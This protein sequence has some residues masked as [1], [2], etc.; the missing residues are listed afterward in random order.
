MSLLALS[1]TNSVSGGYE[2]GNSLKLEDD[3][4]EGMAKNFTGDGDRRT[5]TY[6]TWVKRTEITGSDSFHLFGASYSNIQ[7]MTNDLLRVELYDG[8]N[9]RYA[10]L[11]RVFRD[12]SAWYH[13]VV[14][15]DSTQST[16][17]DRVKIYI[18]GVQDTSFNNSTYT[19][20]SQNDQFDFGS[21]SA[22]Y[23]F[24][25][26][27]AGGS[28]DRRFCGYVAET[29]YVN[30]T[31]LDETS[32]GEFDSDTGIWIPKEYTGS[33]GSKGFYFK[34]D[35]SSNL[36]KDSASSGIGDFTL[37]NITAADQAVDTPTNNFCTLSPLN[38]E[39]NGGGDVEYTEGA[40]KAK[41]LAAD[42]PASGSMAITKGK[43]YFEC[44]A[45]SNSE[46]MAGWGV[47]NS[48]GTSTD[49][50]GN[51][52]YSFAVHPV[53]RVYY[54]GN[55]YIDFSPSVSFDTNDIISVAIDAD[56]GFCYWAKNGTY[57]NSATPTSGATGTGGFN[58]LS[59]S[60]GANMKIVDGDFL[61]PAFRVNY[62]TNSGILL[63]FGGYTTITISSAASDAN[64]YGV[65]EYAPPSGYYAL[66][67]K[68]LAEFG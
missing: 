10:D 23:Q 13:I 7:F 2:I 43:W 67:T 42:E 45:L 54:Y 20:M 66:C 27:F 68:N 18:N 34:F 44:K 65:F 25:Y 61:V 36:G 19:N 33:H 26:Y 28:N 40:T 35:D 47:P 16:A 64:G 21:A 62:Y 50:P 46:I 6:S 38:T 39:N 12:T 5:W 53:G 49:N 37:T 51:D 9:T 58:Y 29:H 15:L 60:T 3:N 31:A 52:E 41:T 55:S 17:A 1:G 32:F 30:G 24:G 8:S 57:M 48:W 59:G 11:N 63:N 14:A 22:N 56:N 4:E